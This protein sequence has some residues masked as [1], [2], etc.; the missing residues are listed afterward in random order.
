MIHAG[1]SEEAVKV[2]KWADFAG[3]SLV[4]VYT[5]S[6]HFLSFRWADIA[7]V[8]QVIATIAERS[9]ETATF[10]VISSLERLS[11]QSLSKQLGRIT[12]CVFNYH[13]VIYIRY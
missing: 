5:N 2:P 1:Y 10:T 11:H 8:L 3:A 7:H 4:L 9:I 13:G 6:V 12:S